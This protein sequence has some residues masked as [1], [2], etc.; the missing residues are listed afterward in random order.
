MPRP[1]R[2]PNSSL[3]QFRRRVPEDV[4]ARAR[5]RAVVI[6]FP[7]A[8]SE[9]GFE[10]LATIGR[11]INFSLRTRD[12]AIAKAR[13]G[14]AVGHLEALWG[15]IR[16][17]PQPLTHK[18]I[19]ALSGEVY[20]RLAVEFE[21]DPGSREH[22]VAVKAFNRAARE[23]RVEQPPPLDP[24]RIRDSFDATS[25]WRPDITAA[26]NALPADER[27]RMMAME[28]R[29]GF[30]T[31]WVLAA[32]GVITDEESRRKLLI[33]VD[34]ASTQ[35]AVKLKG[36]AD[37]NYS[38]DPNASRFPAWEMQS[39]ASRGPTPSLTFDQLF[40][41][42]QR[43]AKPAASTIT[44]W[45]GHVR[46]FIQHLGHDDP[47]RVTRDDVVAFKD[48]LIE[49]GL[50]G[51][52]DGQLATIKRLF[53]Y[54]VDNGLFAS[55]PAQGVKV[56]RRRSAGD[57]KLPYTDEE[58]TRILLLANA[59]TNPARRW[60]PWLMALSG[61]RVG[62]VAQLWGRRVTVKDDITVMKIAPAED[63]GSLKNEG[64]ERAVP[65]HP[66]IIEL[67]FLD[68]VRRKGD[69]PL[70]YGRNG[71]PAARRSPEG[72]RHASKG[73]ANRLAEWIRDQGFTDKRKSPNHAFRHWFKSACMRAG[74]LESIAD[75]IQGHAGD[76]VADVYRHADLQMKAE[77]IRKIKVPP[78]SKRGDS[79]AIQGA[80]YSSAERTRP[81]ASSSTHPNSLG[82]A[83]SKA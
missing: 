22:W 2:R 41:R 61:A 65:I 7:T 9:A 81:S 73:V 82:L 45:R 34:R 17:G 67:G 38:P 76:T 15:A 60:L 43:E 12:P 63:G 37:G 66:A 40:Q 55:N 83:R 44:T 49:R 6:P 32:R 39:V 58:V 68:F 69:G 54:G 71:R 79:G 28:H 13:N 24:E 80:T 47:R 30:L 36:N 64:S 3:H 53:G 29:F 31:D 26:L 21:Q 75:A 51:V 11:E 72:G 5:G 10:A 57:S 74:I 27:R 59:E 77:A 52:R 33:E 25:P 35:A 16:K 70:F 8:G 48:A 14:I 78:V 56:A 46:Q 42:W 18:Q 4:L 19:I 20:R 23:G 50:K 62:E 1:V